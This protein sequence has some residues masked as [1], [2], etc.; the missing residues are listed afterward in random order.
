[1]KIVGLVLAIILLGYGV[2]TTKVYSSLKTSVINKFFTESKIDY[3]GYQ[4]LYYAT[5]TNIGTTTIYY[6]ISSTTATTTW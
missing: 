1:M 5:S 6:L 4:T 2:S 3:R